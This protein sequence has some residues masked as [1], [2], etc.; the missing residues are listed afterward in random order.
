[1]GGRRIFGSGVVD[2]LGQETRLE[3]SADDILDS[4]SSRLGSK[5][6]ENRWEVYHAEP[7]H[8]FTNPTHLGGG[9]PLT[10]FR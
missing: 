10:E 9:N 7:Y 2:A 6:T 4:E 3:Q 8:V 5:I 1:M